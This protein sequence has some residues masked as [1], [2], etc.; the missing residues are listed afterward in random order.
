MIISVL[1][2]ELAEFMYAGITAYIMQNAENLAT[3]RALPEIIEAFSFHV[4]ARMRALTQRCTRKRFAQT[5]FE[6]CLTIHQ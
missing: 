6:P 2:T 3:F 4:S 5:H 1:H